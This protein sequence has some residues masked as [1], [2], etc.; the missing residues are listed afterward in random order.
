MSTLWNVFT[1]SLIS[2]VISWTMGWKDAQKL[3]AIV[4]LASSILIF[5]LDKVP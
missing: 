3:A 4:L 2:L 1:L 5:L